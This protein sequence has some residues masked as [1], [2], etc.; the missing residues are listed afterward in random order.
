M[1]G[2]LIVIMK[3]ALRFLGQV[4]ELPEKADRHGGTERELQRGASRVIPVIQVDIPKEKTAVPLVLL[5]GAP[6]D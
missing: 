2:L 5:G 3:I 6:V 4:Y 1:R